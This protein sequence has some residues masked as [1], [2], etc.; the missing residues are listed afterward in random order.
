M[1]S[2]KVFAGIDLS[3]S[4]R[5][6]TVALLSPRLDVLSLKVQSP[7]ETVGELAARTEIV[8]VVNGPLHPCAAIEESDPPAMDPPRKSLERHMRAADGELSRRGIP[9]RRLPALESDAPAWMRCG[10]GLARQL[11]ARGFAEG[12]D[13]CAEPRVLLESQPAACAAVLLGRLPYPRDAL[14]GRIQRQLVLLRERVALTDPMDALEELTAHHIL[15]GRME[16]KGILGAGELDALLAA[17]TAWRA[18]T[19]PDSV[20]WLGDDADGWMCLPVKE[21]LEKYSKGFVIPA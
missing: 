6:L 1:E 8:I 16:L 10:F 14:E 20:A 9:F 13:A 11:A 18:H 17:F 5:G 15:S 2:E 21:L 12:K 3:T 4:R 7:D 19:H